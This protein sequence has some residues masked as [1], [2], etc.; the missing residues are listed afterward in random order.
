MMTDLLYAV[1]IFAVLCACAYLG[2]AVRARLPAHHQG[3]ETFE[4]MALTIGM[5]VTFAALVL[6]LVTNAAK[7]R[8][9][10]AAHERQQYA[11]VLTAL[12]QCL[13][14]VGPAGDAARADMR[15]YVAAVIAS[16]WPAEKPPSGVTYPNTKDMPLLG[17]TPVLAGLMN[18]I[19]QQV[20][21]LAASTPAQSHV[22]D[23]CRSVYDQVQTARRA[24][25][26][27]V[28]GGLSAPFYRMLV[29]WLIVIFASFGLI[30]PRHS[31]SMIT[32]VLC[33]FSLSTALFVVVDLDR[34][35]GG[36]FAISSSTMREALAA[37]MRPE[38]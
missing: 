8:Y 1:A 14:D 31:L 15:S 5:L 27:D 36:V 32:I 35:Y 11:L 23:R 30:S 20:D 29:F 26:E 3:R 19:G 37:M 4:M 34:P 17:A 21:G 13:R 6:G 9:D 38:E 18:R 10:G 24:V 16:T 25:I 12:D 22:A 2:M 7:A 33:A 28:R